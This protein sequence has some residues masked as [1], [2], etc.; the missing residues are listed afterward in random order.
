MIFTCFGCIS[1]STG[2][3]S[4]CLQLKV[5]ANLTCKKLVVLVDRQNTIVYLG[6]LSY[7]DIFYTKLHRR[8]SGWRSTTII[9]PNTW[10]DHLGHHHDYWIYTSDVAD[11]SR[12]EP[13]RAW[14][15]E[16]DPSLMIRST[17]E[18]DTRRWTW[19]ITSNCDRIGSGK[20]TV[21]FGRAANPIVT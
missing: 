14:W 9:E 18:G 17:G 4:Q 19:E 6:L 11:L 21:S 12:R 8:L 10:L 20:M 5:P 2:Q 3:L 16:M 1:L 7:Q 15:L 13:L